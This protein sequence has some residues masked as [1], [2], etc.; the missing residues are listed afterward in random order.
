MSTTVVPLRPISPVKDRSSAPVDTVALRTVKPTKTT[1]NMLSCRFEMKY[2]I[3]EA[4]AQ[5]VLGFVQM[6]LPLDKYSQSV[7]GGQYQLSSLYLDSHNLQ[8]CRESL[9]GTKNRFKLRV[10]T[11]SDELTSPVFFEIKRRMNGIILKDRAKKNRCCC[12]QILRSSAGQIGRLNSSKDHDALTQ[13]LLYV[14]SINAAPIVKVRYS[15]MAFEDDSHNR[16]RI[17]FDRQ[18]AFKVVNTI[19]LSMNG[20]GWQYQMEPGVVLEIKFTNHYPAWIGYMIS[21][22][23]LQ[24]R[25]FS[26]Y[27]RSIEKSN[28][29]KFCSPQIPAGRIYSI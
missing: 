12:E 3:S 23:G 10:R 17:T 26:K 13:F 14:N 19:D 7:K 4:M 1:D 5:R 22:L 18:L 28:L 21:T 11:Y 27:A 9:D 16:V 25:S 15:R 24:R 8:L 29:M 6:H 20:G 2:F